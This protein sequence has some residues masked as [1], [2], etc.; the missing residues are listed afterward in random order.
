MV[1]EATEIFTTQILDKVLST[2]NFFSIFEIIGFIFT[3]FK[4][5]FLKHFSVEKN[6]NIIMAKGVPDNTYF[7]QTEVYDKVFGNTEICNVSIVVKQITNEV[8][9]RSGS[10]RFEGKETAIFFFF[11]GFII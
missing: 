11:L 8:V 7:F 9:T 2:E 6:G 10:V 3:I 4:S 1:A 5:L